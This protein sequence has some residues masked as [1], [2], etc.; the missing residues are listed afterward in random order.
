M[1][2]LPAVA[3]IVVDCVVV[4]A[5]IEI[6]KV[7]AVA[8][9]GIVTED[10]TATAELLLAKDMLIPALGAGPVSDTVQP[11]DADPTTDVLV[12]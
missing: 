8:A 4:T 2:T 10:G 7:T 11:S 12:H 6:L 1:E 9:A 3:L 5:E